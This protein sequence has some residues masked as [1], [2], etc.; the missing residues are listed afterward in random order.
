M[1]RVTVESLDGATVRAWNAGEDDAP[2]LL[3][4]HG[5]ER[6]PGEAPFLHRLAQTRRVLAPEHP[7]YGESTGLEAMDHVLDLVLHYRRLVERTFTGPVDVIGHSLGGMF[8][9]EFAAI[10]PHLT[11]SLTL[12]SPYGLWLEEDPLPDPFV[13]S[14]KELRTAI[15]SDPQ[16]APD[17]ETSL[18]LPGAADP[19]AKV[20]DRARN[21]G[22]ATKFM[23]PIPDHGLR[24]RLPL[25]GARTLVVRGTDDQLVPQS[26][27]E[28]FVR[29][30]PDAR[31]AAVEAAGHLPMLERPTEFGDLLEA[32]LD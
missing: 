27:T 8:A 29:L 30:I 19:H 17:P 22:A 1:S 25:I 21:M 20:Y 14:E 5:F 3:Y 10:C 13:L 11:S 24:R 2:G 9:A 32:F 26:Y 12:V 4:L 28:E 7:G 6:H 16:A 23:W 31:F 18:P 15:W